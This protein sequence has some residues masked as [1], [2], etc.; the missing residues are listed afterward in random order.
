MY[1]F[2]FF[3]FNLGTENDTSAVTANIL[4]FQLETTATPLR[5]NV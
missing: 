1:P 4:E 5:K 3:H 2:E